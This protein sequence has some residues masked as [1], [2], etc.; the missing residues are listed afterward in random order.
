MDEIEAI[1]KFELCIGGTE[2]HWRREAALG[3][4]MG[5]YE[6]CIAQTRIGW[7]TLGFFAFYR[8]KLSGRTQLY[9]RETTEDTRESKTRT[10][11]KL[12][13]ASIA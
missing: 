5:F 6:G 11:C 4:G 12:V 13:T 10:E 9:T 8:R 3:M 7:M 1:E 2:R